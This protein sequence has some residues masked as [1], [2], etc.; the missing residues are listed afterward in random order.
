MINVFHLSI[1]RKCI[2]L[3]FKE[4]ER[5]YRPIPFWSWND[6]LDTE[7]TTRQIGL[8]DEQG[9]GGV[10]MHARGGL[11]TPY[12]GDEWFGNVDAC[13]EECEKR[14]MHPWAYDENGWPSGF[15]DGKVN[16]K[17]IGYQQKCLRYEKINIIAW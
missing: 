16:G 3:N 17:G 1:I 15:G 12:M 5:K 11:K 6:K 13:I 10:F 9:I 2:K 14:G 4:I 8:M 7:E